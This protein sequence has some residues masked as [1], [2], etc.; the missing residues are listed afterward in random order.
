MP[1]EEIQTAQVLDYMQRNGG[2]SG[3][4]AFSKLEIERLPARIWDIRNKLG[5]AIDDMWEYKYD[6]DGKVIKKWKRYFIA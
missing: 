1:Q 3:M 5:I 6:D 2:I 4:E